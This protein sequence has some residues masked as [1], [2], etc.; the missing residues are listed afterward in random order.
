MNRTLAW[1]EKNVAQTRLRDS[2]TGKMV[3]ADGQKM[4]AA[5]FRHDTSRNLDPQ[6]HTHAVL[7]N[8]LQGGDGKWRTMANEKLYASKMLIGAIYRGELAREVKELGYGIEKTHADGRFEIAGVSRK[9]VEAFSTRRA[10]IVAAMNA[11]G[12]GDPD[13]NPRIAER[14]ALMTRAHKRDVDHEGL[15][16]H[17]EKQA[18]EL[19][20]DARALA[21]SALDRSALARTEPERTAG[22]EA[23]PQRSAASKGNGSLPGEVLPRISTSAA[24][25]DARPEAEGEP[26][27]GEIAREAVAWAVAH[28]SER[29]AVF[30]RTGL[31]AAAL[32]WDPGAVR[33]GDAERAVGELV[34]NGALHA[35]SRPVPGE[36]LTTDKAVADEKETIALMLE[37]RDRGTA[38]MRARRVDKL[39]RKGPLTEGQKA[40][41][42]LILS[43]EDRVVGV[44]GYAGT[45]KTRM[46]NR[47]RALL[48]KQGYELKGLAPSA[49]A[50][51]TLAAEADIETETLQR[52]L[53][54]NAG[55]AEGRLT[56]KGAKAMRETF[57]RT[58]LVVDEGSLASTVQARNLLRIAREIRLPKV[59][60]VGDGKQLDAVDAGKPFVQ[61]QQA[62]MRTATMSEIMRQKEPALKEAVEASLAGDIKKAFEKLGPN[63]EA[64]EPKNLAGAA[65]ARW[66]RLSPQDRERTGLMAPSHALRVQINDIVRQ[67]L[68]R[69]G[70]IDGKRL[71]VERLVSKGTPMRRRRSRAITPGGTWWFFTGPTSASALR[72]A[73]NCGYWG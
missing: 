5:T 36:S 40:A 72:K 18:E 64:V 55:V 20:F 6:L 9:V 59:V 30:S 69:E 8:M 45:G 49:S 71:T 65:A 58:V 48:E 46:L 34:E 63:I 50:A 70:N 44:Q 31:L 66:L 51:Q 22:S 25:A 54:R 14:A 32:A 41:V 19:G 62:G 10:A 37:G 16:A 29:E 4:V 13:A 11:R 23:P 73:T 33:V 39:L 57:K 56:E 17:W 26:R 7:A 27:K 28:L 38:P 52:F 47:A 3:R 68:T 1:V 61:L 2:K 67:R 35:A 15:R 43:E 53:L 24:G 60:L 42:K 12:L 21:H